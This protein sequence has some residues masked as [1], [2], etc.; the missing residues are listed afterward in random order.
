MMKY[1]ISLGSNMGDR[2]LALSD[3]RTWMHENV[4]EIATE[5]SI[6][7]TAPWGMESVTSFYNQVVVIRTA[8]LPEEVLSLLLGYEGSKGRIRDADTYQDRPIDLDILYVDDMVITSDSLSV[9]HPRIQERRFILE[10]LCE[11][12][13]NSVHPVLKRTHRELLETCRD[14]LSVNKIS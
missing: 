10:P 8:M 7:E 9:P 5:S 3:A 12:S 14:S 11:I 6:Y 13:Q 1:W 4:G 2:L